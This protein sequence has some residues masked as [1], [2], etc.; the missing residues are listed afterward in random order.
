MHSPEEQLSRALKDASRLIVAGQLYRH[1]KSPEM[2]Y[3]VIH[4]AIMEAD[5]QVAVVYEAQY[6]DH[7]TFVRPI[8]SWLD[9]IEVNGLR[10][11]RFQRLETDSIDS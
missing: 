4:L 3:K 11:K 6:G 10:I 1:Y 5:E 7:L 8:D 2:V 9:D